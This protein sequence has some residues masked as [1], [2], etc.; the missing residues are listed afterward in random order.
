MKLLSPNSQFGV[1]LSFELLALKTDE[2]KDK[3]NQDTNEN[4]EVE[5][6]ER[7]RVC[8]CER[9]KEREYV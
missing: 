5:K 3:V 2:P 9:E 1:V 7:A 6:S 4:R 8:V